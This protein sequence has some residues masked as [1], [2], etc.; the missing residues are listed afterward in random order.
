MSVN[1]I[2]DDKWIKF[3][4]PKVGKNQLYAAYGKFTSPIKMRD[5]KEIY[6]KH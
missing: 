3:T 6:N 1:N 2:H 5:W 4:H